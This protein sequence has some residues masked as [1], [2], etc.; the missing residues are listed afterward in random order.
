LINSERRSTKTLSQRTF[1][2]L[3]VFHD[4]VPASAADSASLGVSILSFLQ[5]HFK[6]YFFSIDYN[7]RFQILDLCVDPDRLKI[8]DSPREKLHAKTFCTDFLQDPQS[9]ANPTTAWLY[10][11]RTSG[12][13]RHYR[14][15]GG[16]FAPGRP[17]RS[18]GG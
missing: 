9:V 8:C 18:R 10:L 12:R 4:R 14:C 7:Y 5:K 15:P 1:R 17:S 16:T 6:Y 2:W 11:G 13:H 3:S